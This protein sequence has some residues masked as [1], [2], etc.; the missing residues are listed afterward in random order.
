VVETK[1]LDSKKIRLL[2]QGCQVAHFQTKPPVLVH[3]GRPLN[4]KFW[5]LIWPFGILYGTWVY[6]V[7]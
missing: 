4:G 6:F 2:L 3:F 7:H 5:C 1:K